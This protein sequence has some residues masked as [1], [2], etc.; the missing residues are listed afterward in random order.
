MYIGGISGQLWTVASTT[1]GVGVGAAICVFVGCWV[2]MRWQQ[3]KSW[4]DDRISGRS[5]L[6]LKR[7]F[8]T[9]L[10]QIA[11][12]KDRRELYAKILRI[13]A[14]LARSEDVSLLLNNPSTKKY[15]VKESVGSKPISFQVGE[16]DA[17]I[18]WLSKY[19][20]SVTRAELVDSPD[21]AEVKSKGLQ[22]C[23]Q[24]HAEAVV[25]LIL[26]GSMIGLINIGCRSDGRDFEDCL[27]DVLD[28][29]SSQFAVTIHNANLYEGLL[30]Q[31]ARLKELDA[32][33][34]QLLANVSHELRTPLNSIIGLSELM[35]EGNDG[36]LSDEQRFHLKMIRTSGQRLLETVSA[37]VDLS[38]LQA[39]RLS[40]D[41]KRINLR[42]M[43]ERISTTVEVN[44]KVDVRV[45]IDENT[46]PIYGDAVWISR[47]FKNLLSNALKYT[48]EGSVFVDYG[49]AGDMLKVGIHDTGI[50]IRKEDQKSIFEGFTQAS[51]GLSREHEGTGIGLSISKKIVELHGGRIW[52]D[53]KPGKGSHFFFTLPLKPNA[54]PSVEIG[55]MM[56]KRAV[57]T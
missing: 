31:N 10:K 51:N 46:P 14:R 42:K 49:K 6:K 54:I 32:L 25:P 50:G 41:V 5:E 47:V 4:V 24:F 1:Y 28:L 16:L 7:I 23:V 48:S 8:D 13:I 27:F 9:Y 35:S 29:M 2:V 53:S 21:F 36:P 52:V 34:S 22:Y 20:K 18:D 39:N 30:R 11:S 3:V 57:N 19:K 37:L 44:G 12:I 17:F 15:I 26:G 55:P 45:D 38:K 43:V 40:L 33:R 56:P